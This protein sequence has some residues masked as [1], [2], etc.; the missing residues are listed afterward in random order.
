[1]ALLGEIEHVLSQLTA[2]AMVDTVHASP[3]C[4]IS[5][6]IGFHLGNTG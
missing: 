6:D 5:Q 4:G 3:E 2:S 1:M